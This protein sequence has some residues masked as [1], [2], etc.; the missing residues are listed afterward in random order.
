MADASLEGNV[1]VLKCAFAFHQK[2]LMEKSNQKIIAGI[3]HELTGQNVTIDCSLETGTKPANFKAADT[4]QE[5]ENFKTISNIF[6]GG[7]LLE[8]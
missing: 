5:P 8:S 3:I 7:E 1:L 4:A 2:R 6:G